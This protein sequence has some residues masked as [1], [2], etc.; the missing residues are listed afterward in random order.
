MKEFTIYSSR[1][2]AELRKRGFKIVGTGIN[3]AHPQFDTYIFE[4]SQE[5]REALTSIT[6]KRN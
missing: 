1:V 6:L 5:L 4:D 2:A 3:E